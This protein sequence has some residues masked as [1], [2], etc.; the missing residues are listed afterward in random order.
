MVYVTRYC[1]FVF[2]VDRSK[3]EERFPMLVG[4]HFKRRKKKS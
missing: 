2:I 3:G 1:F 4:N